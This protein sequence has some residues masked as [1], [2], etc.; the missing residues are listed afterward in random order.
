MSESFK[1][2]LCGYDRFTLYA[3]KARAAQPAQTA[4]FGL[5]TVTKAEPA[6]PEHLTATCLLCWCEHAHEEIRGKRIRG[7]LDF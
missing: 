3:H 4:L 2:R 6:T 7:P 1:C 5:V